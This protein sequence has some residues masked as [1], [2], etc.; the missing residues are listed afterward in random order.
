[1]EL[2][3]IVERLRLLRTEDE[4]VCWTLHG[5]AERGIDDEDST[6]DNDGRASVRTPDGTHSSEVDVALPFTNI[7][8]DLKFECTIDVDSLIIVTR[9]LSIRIGAPF[10]LVGHGLIDIVE[11]AKNLRIHCE[12][13]PEIHTDTSTVIHFGD[14]R[15]AIPNQH[16]FVV[17]RRSHDEEPEVVRS[18]FYEQVILQSLRA[19]GNAGLL[20]RMPASYKSMERRA[21]TKNGTYALLTSVVGGEFAHV[22]LRHARDK[23]QELF[24]DRWE[25]V[26]D[27]MGLKGLTSCTLGSM[28]LPEL[29]GSLTRRQFASTT[30]TLM[31]DFR[32]R[33]GF[34]TDWCCGLDTSDPS[35]HAYADFGITMIPCMSANP[36]RTVLWAKSVIQTKFVRWLHERP[37]GYGPRTLHYD[38]F[39]N[40]PSVCA[41]RAR[42]D[43]TACSA[44]TSF[45]AGGAEDLLQFDRPRKMTYVQAYHT[46]RYRSATR[47]L[48]PLEWIGK[49]RHVTWSDAVDI[50]NSTRDLAEAI[51]E[52][53]ERDVADHGVRLEFRFGLNK[54]PFPSMSGVS[55]VAA[56][57]FGEPDTQESTEQNLWAIALKWT[58][59]VFSRKTVLVCATKHLNDYLRLTAECYRA[60]ARRAAE[61]LSQMS[62]FTDGTFIPEQAFA[63]R[64]LH[65]LMISV[66]ILQ[67]ALLRRQPSDETWFRQLVLYVSGFAPMPIGPHGLRSKLWQRFENFYL[68]VMDADAIAASR[69]PKIRFRGVDHDEHERALH[70]LRYSSERGSAALKQPDFVQARVLGHRV[71]EAY[72]GGRGVPTADFTQETSRPHDHGRLLTDLAKDGPSVEDFWSVFLRIFFL[73]MQSVRFFGAGMTAESFRFSEPCWRQ[74]AEKNHWFVVLKEP[75]QSAQCEFTS[76]KIF[77]LELNQRADAQEWAWAVTMQKLFELDRLG[78]VGPLFKVFSERTR[79]GFASDV[80]F[81]NALDSFLINE[82]QNLISCLPDFQTQKDKKTAILH[83]RHRGHIVNHVR[84]AHEYYERLELH[85]QPLQRQAGSTHVAS[86]PHQAEIAAFQAFIH[87]RTWA[88]WTATPMGGNNK[89]THF[90]HELVHKLINTFEERYHPKRCRYID[91]LLDKAKTFYDTV[92]ND[93]S[94][95]GTSLVNLDKEGVKRR[96]LYRK[97]ARLQ[98]Q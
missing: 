6:S 55:M 85:L 23:L 81:S 95:Q 75:R 25:F 74:L 93:P 49:H 42:M 67:T 39:A 78:D 68:E 12:K 3:R 26:I 30:A 46:T 71:R 73:G 41:F 34:M 7:D 56:S 40:F 61:Q 43:R 2:P 5:V 17:V 66:H 9:D 24:P 48:R 80:Q 44:I 22:F 97:K 28:T 45:A 35:I 15:V 60:T 58:C 98:P 79:R 27:S 37:S 64:P 36:G 4:K 89:L 62:D 38:T 87:D 8:N 33:T 91:F 83:I 19:V 76:T 31:R 53:T 72:F 82:T 84:G 94:M 11:R 18:T 88:R 57:F 14:F 32:A 52:E 50:Y 20:A 51:R 65:A 16:V 59:D 63:R 21:Q 92:K 69:V 13:F 86:N 54:H 77:G 10:T 29:N 70:L 47:A 90:E 1:M 96:V